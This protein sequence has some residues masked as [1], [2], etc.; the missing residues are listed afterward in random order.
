MALEPLTLTVEEAGEL[1]GISRAL[2]YDLV[3]QGHLP[4][5]RLGRRIVVSRKALVDFVDA[6]ASS[7]NGEPSRHRAEAPGRSDP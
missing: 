2:A 6:A 5:L 3:R 7:G 1:L 4:S